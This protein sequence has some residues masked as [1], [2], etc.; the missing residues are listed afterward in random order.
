M[1]ERTFA[2]LSNYRPSSKEYEVNTT[3]STG[4]V[5]LTCIQPCFNAFPYHLHLVSE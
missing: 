4:M 2:G 5:Y 3:A 1:V